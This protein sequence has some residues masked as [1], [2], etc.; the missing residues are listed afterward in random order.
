MEQ[1]AI[2]TYLLK[3]AAFCN[4]NCS[5]CFMFNLQDTTYRGKEKIMPLEIV[6]AAANKMVELARQQNINSLNISFHGGEPLLAGKDWF[7]RAI[8]ILREAGGD[9]VSFH[10][11]VQTNAVLID[12]EWLD[13]FQD[14]GIDVGVSL[15]GP[16]EINDR[17]RLNFAGDSTYEKTVAGIKK[18]QERD[19]LFG[20]VL[21]VID[22]S[23]HGLD[24]YRHFRELGIK[25]IDFLW[26]LDFNWNSP[27]P[28][29]LVADQTPF[30]DYLIPIFDEWWHRDG[31]A[32]SV[33]YFESILRGL[34]GARIGLDSLGGNPINI[35]AIDTDGSVEP[36]DSLRSGDDGFTDVGLRIQRDPLSELYDK[37]LFQAALS[38][39]N[40]LCEKC[41]ACVFG[42]TCGGG[43]M[44]HRYS[45]ANGF[46]N[47]SVY[48]RD[49]WKLI[50]HILATAMSEVE[51]PF[52]E[53]PPS[54][55]I[56]VPQLAAPDVEASSR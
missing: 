44:P 4:L 42:D 20:G 16:R 52:Q 46:D 23:T 5:Y 37:E 53:A 48:C 41:K 31:D 47:P 17:A 28:S 7:R 14:H 38:G 36:L 32:I 50:N 51:K 39:R 55:R 11:G 1:V 27:P 45:R 43:Y 29:L 9:H 34:V 54:L 26:P 15:D 35:V 21:C 25:R 6:Q 22:P 56:K 2:N 19:G 40:G 8:A 13:L 3:I 49:L 12:D 24:I 18:L 30:A 33:R 10:F